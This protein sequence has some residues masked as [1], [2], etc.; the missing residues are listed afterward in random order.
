M[1]RG[2]DAWLSPRSRH[3]AQEAHQA[4]A[5]RSNLLSNPNLRG[6]PRRDHPSQQPH[7]AVQPARHAPRSPR[8]AALHDG[9]HSP[10]SVRAAGRGAGEDYSSQRPRGAAPAPSAWK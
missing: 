6:P 1:L 9:P 7:G 8:P 2:G 3:V 4:P 10:R 5:K